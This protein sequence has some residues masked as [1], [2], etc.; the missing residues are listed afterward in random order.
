MSV[1]E[2]LRRAFVVLLFLGF[3]LSLPVVAQTLTIRLLNG[4]TGKPI[5]NKHMTVRWGDSL[6]NPT[7]VLIGKNG[8]GSFDV[9]TG[10]TQ[11]KL[12]SP[13]SLKEPYRD[14]YMGCNDPELKKVEVKQVV[15]TGYVAHNLCSRHTVKPK[16]G[17]IVFWA[18]PMPWWLKLNI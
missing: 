1:E 8:I 12:E 18:K 11:F 14:A 16:P 17:E 4:K 13:T 2:P 3:N 10:R 9:Q 6:F 15:D 5:A 7:N